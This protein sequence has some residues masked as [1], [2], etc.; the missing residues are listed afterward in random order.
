MNWKGLDFMTTPYLVIGVGNAYRSDDRAGLAVLEALRARLPP[1]I[2]CIE[3][4]G[5]G[6]TL[7]D[8]WTPTS[9]IILIDAALSAA[10]A[11]TIQRFDA[12]NQPLPTG[13]SFA[14]THHFGIAEAIHLARILGC[15]PESLTIYAIVG[16]NFMAG[17]ELSPEVEHAVQEVVAL[18]QDM[19]CFNR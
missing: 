14:S 10:P 19:R 2:T 9:K 6:T 5:D 17:Q 16:K 12:F 11:G 13:F 15:L 7:L 1:E 3:S 8:L 4:N 18:L